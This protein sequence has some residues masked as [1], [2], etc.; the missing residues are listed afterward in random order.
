MPLTFK[1]FSQYLKLF[2]LLNEFGR[3]K[4]TLFME[5]VFV[6]LILLLNSSLELSCYQSTQADIQISTKLSTNKILLLKSFVLLLAL[7]DLKE[8]KC[9][10]SIENI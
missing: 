6:N 1:D 7:N 10:L 8:E 2:V 3:Y 5:I 9:I 4:L